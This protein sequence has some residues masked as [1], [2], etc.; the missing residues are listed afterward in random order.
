MSCLADFNNRTENIHT[1][2]ACDRLSAYHRKWKYRGYQKCSAKISGHAVV[3]LVEA[4]YYKQPGR[5]FETRSG[6]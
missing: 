4:L 5:G 1:E 6:H 3:Q 2:K